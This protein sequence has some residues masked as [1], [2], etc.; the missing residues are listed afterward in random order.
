MCSSKQ[1]MLKR[2]L[3]KLLNFS[4]FHLEIRRLVLHRI[5]IQRLKL[6]QIR[7][8]PDPGSEV[9]ILRNFDFIAFS[10]LILFSGDRHL[11][12]RRVKLCK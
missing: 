8:D 6:M 12:G 10:N 9:R 5:R 1:K 7:E 4:P 2:S 3:F 11:R